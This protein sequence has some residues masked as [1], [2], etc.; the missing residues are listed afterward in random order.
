M[1]K[2]YTFLILFLFSVVSIAQYVEIPD[3]NFRKK[4]KVLVP[5]CFNGELLDTNCAGNYTGRPDLS[6]F[7]K[8][9]I[10]ITEDSIYSME[11][12]QYF[13]SITALIC[14]RNKLKYL[15]ALPFSLQILSCEY[16]QLASL[17]SLPNSLT[18]LNCSSNRLTILPALPNQLSELNCYANQ[19]SSIPTLPNSLRTLNCMFNNLISLPTL[20]ANL[21][22]LNCSHN[23]L[24]S[25]PMIYN[26]RILDCSYNQLT[27]L[28]S[29][30][31]YM[32]RLICNSNL[33]TCLPYLPI[34]LSYLVTDVSCIPNYPSNPSKYFHFDSNVYNICTNPDGCPDPTSISNEKLEIL[35]EKLFFPN[36]SITGVFK[37]QAKIPF[38][39]V[40][41][42][43]LAQR[44]VLEKEG[45]LETIDLSDQP[46]GIYIAKLQTQEGIKLEKLIVE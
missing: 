40:Q 30:A 17:P 31:S 33:I 9:S 29:L 4:L 21:R 32:D 25:L 1:K 46:K 26:L 42:T 5:N 23:F 36:P 45:L 10:E 12:I 14:Y 43:D 34:S 44:I 37:L 22:G 38:I 35:D 20:N 41:I 8:N 16:N 11:G 3:S 18:S 7:Y 39:H 24:T 15:P 6:G 13:N 19:L 27:S 2:I 28:S